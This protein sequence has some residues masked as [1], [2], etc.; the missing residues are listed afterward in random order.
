MQNK[1]AV[2]SHLVHYYLILFPLMLSFLLYSQECCYAMC[3]YYISTFWLQLLTHSRLHVTRLPDPHTYIQIS[4]ILPLGKQHLLLIC[5]LPISR[6]Q[7][8]PV[9]WIPMMSACT[10]CHENC[11]I[12]E[13]LENS[14]TQPS[15]QEGKATDAHFSATL[16]IY[17]LVA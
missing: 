12:P 14:S 3:H 7:V 4:P 13:Y 8:V 15:Y 16:N 17:S 5:L 10:G 6:L 2:Y 1:H 11:Y 9:T